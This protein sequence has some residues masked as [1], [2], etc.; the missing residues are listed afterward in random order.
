VSGATSYSWTVPSGSTITAGQGT[1][2]ITVTFGSTSGT[3]AVT[4]NSSCGSSSA[5]TLAVTILATPP[6]IPGFITGYTSVA[7]AQTGVIYSIGAV[8]GAASYTWTIPAGTTI[9]SG[10]T[11][12][13]ITV[14]WG[15][16]SGNICVTATNGCGTSAASCKAITVFATPSGNNQAFSYTGV[17]QTFTIPP[18]IT[19]ILVIAN[20]AAGGSNNKSGTGGNIVGNVTVTAA[21]M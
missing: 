3:I 6:A 9:T 5:K 15:T 19:S 4:A 2:S 12:T 20:G 13:S 11:T 7:S 14:N 21:T 10:Q 18:G 17:V 16:T 8:S 1:S